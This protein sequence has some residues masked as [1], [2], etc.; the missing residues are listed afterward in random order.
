M[1]IQMNTKY[2]FVTGGV[3]S[4]SW[5]PRWSRQLELLS[6]IEQHQKADHFYFEEGVRIMRLAQRA[7]DL[8]VVQPQTEKRKLL[9][10][11]LLNCTFDG[12]KLSPVYKKPFCWLAEGSLRPVWRAIRDD[13]TNFLGSEECR[14]L[15]QLAM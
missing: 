1:V 12:E 5:W 15:A 7:Y 6:S 11:L 9:N 8:W 2:V 14:E 10:I 3:V 13:F 4:A